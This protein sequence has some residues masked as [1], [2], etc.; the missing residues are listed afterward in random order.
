MEIALGAQTENGQL[1]QALEDRSPMTADK[2]A[3]TQDL[4][5]DDEMRTASQERELEEAARRYEALIR[6]HNDA[7]ANGLDYQI[8]M[9]ENDDDS[10]VSESNS[11]NRRESA[12]CANGNGS[13]G[14]GSD[15]GGSGG[16]AIDMVNTS[17]QQW[18]C[19]KCT[20][21]NEFQQQQCTICGTSRPWDCPRCTYRNSAGQKKCE[22]CHQEVPTRPFDDYEDTSVNGGGGGGV[23]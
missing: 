4:C 20:F 16:A 1:Q 22:L 6:A 11:E 15:G 8:K 2:M 7:I 13:G 3:L 12:N 14:G 5:E 10:D 9:M 18:S 23:L 19:H 21:A 17:E